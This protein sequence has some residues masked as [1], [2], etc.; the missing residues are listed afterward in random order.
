VNQESLS[1]KDIIEKKRQKEQKDA[2]AALPR[3][4]S[5]ALLT[6]DGISR[7]H[8]GDDDVKLTAT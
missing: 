2:R 7:A 1:S 5:L 3:N 6:L 8:F 4:L